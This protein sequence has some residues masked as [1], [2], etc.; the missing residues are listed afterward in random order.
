M[1]GEWLLAIQKKLAAKHPE[2]SAAVKVNGAEELAG[3]ERQYAF[4]ISDDLTFA[5]R[6]HEQLSSEPPCS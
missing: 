4:W 3:D 5:S 1:A 6:E 2:L